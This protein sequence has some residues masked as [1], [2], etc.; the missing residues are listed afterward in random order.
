MIIYVDMASVYVDIVLYVDLL[1]YTYRYL[2]I[3][4]TVTVVCYPKF[5]RR[6][7]S[8]QVVATG[9]CY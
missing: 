4:P 6:L 1:Y 7:R 9:S 2:V 3:G 8:E 5:M